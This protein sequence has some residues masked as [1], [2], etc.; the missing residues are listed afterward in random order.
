M[1]EFTGKVALIT[2]GASGIGEA[3]ALTFARAGARVVIADRNKERGDMLTKQLRD[4]GGEV[5]FVETNVSDPEDVQT[6]IMRTIDTFGQLDI[7]VNSAGIVGESNPVGD[8]SIAGWQH[9][10]EVNLNAVF[11]CMHYEIPPMVQSGSGVIV[12]LASVWG[13]VGKDTIAAY[14]A[15][16]HGVIGLTKSAALEYA[17]R[18]LRINA[19]A[20]GFIDTPLATYS[21]EQRQAFSALHALGRFGEAQEVANMVAFLCSEQAS[22][23]TGGCYL[24]D[25]GLT[26]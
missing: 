22:F 14:S 6:M 2:G 1:Y 16:K 7:A 8:L 11:Y 17:K 5:L 26:A 3:C 15:A 23:L 19:V 4:R 18:G 12:N 20:P 21:D 10:I 24:V 25:G 9:V 13:V